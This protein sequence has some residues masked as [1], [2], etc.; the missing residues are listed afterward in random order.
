MTKS[1]SETKGAQPEPAE[2]KKDYDAYEAGRRH[3]RESWIKVAVECKRCGGTGGILVDD[4]SQG[5][6][7]W[8]YEVDCPRCKGEG[9]VVG[10]EP[11]SARPASEPTEELFGGM[12]RAE[13]KAWAAGWQEGWAGRMAS[14]GLDPW[15][16]A[17]SEASPA[18]ITG[19]WTSGTVQGSK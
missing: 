9:V 18:Q 5:P 11:V 6:D 16:P 12:T 3:E 19:G 17:A 1:E 8:P 13:R 14:F 4:H 2:L 10:A 7:G 15:T